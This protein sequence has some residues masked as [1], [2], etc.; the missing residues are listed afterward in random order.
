MPDK[1]QKS[2]AQYSAPQGD[3]IPTLSFQV[4]ENTKER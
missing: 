4:P 3:A 2:A 1:M